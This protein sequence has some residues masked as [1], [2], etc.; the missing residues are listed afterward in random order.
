MESYSV[1]RRDN[2]GTLVL[3]DD[4]TS[5]TLPG[6]YHV[7]GRGKHVEVEVKPQAAGRSACLCDTGAGVHQE[8]QRRCDSL[9]SCC[10][11]FVMMIS[12]II[13]SAA[14]F[15]TVGWLLVKRIERVLQTLVRILIERGLLPMFP[16]V[17]PQI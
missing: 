14:V 6:L 9:A 10:I 7:Y 13:V 2:D 16:A 17:S 11:F 5:R 8:K 3:L 12:L 1:W 4:E 15:G